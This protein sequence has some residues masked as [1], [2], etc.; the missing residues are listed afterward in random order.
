VL[1]GVRNNLV[2]LRQLPC[3]VT[4]AASEAER[5]EIAA[6]RHGSAGFERLARAEQALV[7]LRRGDLA[8]AGAWAAGLAPASNL[9]AY[10]R[11]P[12]ALVLARLWIAQGRT[13]EA[14]CLLGDL[15]VVANAAGRLASVIEIQ[16]L[17]TLALERAGSPL[18]AL[19]A[20]REAL[21]QSEQGGFVHVFLDEGESI[22]RLL[23]RAADGHPL[24]ARLASA[25]PPDTPMSS[26]GGLLSRREDE[27]LELLAEGRTNREIGERLVITQN[28][29]KAHLH[30]LATKLD[31]SNRTTILAHAGSRQAAEPKTGVRVRCLLAR[32]AVREGVDQTSSSSGSRSSSSASAGSRSGRN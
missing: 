31:G 9:L 14:L 20:I 2:R 28:T 11:E 21:R 32:E 15:L 6:R 30:H 5:A 22:V 16:V 3:K 18:E 12:E 17:R 25:I 19:A 27:V 24:S 26:T 13:D 29:V 4:E 1:I 10:P 7:S 23:R 8:G